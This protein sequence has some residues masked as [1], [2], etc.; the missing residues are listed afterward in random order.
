LAVKSVH[1]E[2]LKEELKRH[3]NTLREIERR[4]LELGASRRED[5]RQYLVKIKNFLRYLKNF[6]SSAKHEETSLQTPESSSGREQS[7]FETIAAKSKADMRK[8]ELESQIQ[9]SLKEEEEL[10]PRAEAHGTAHEELDD[11]YSGIFDGPTPGFP[12]EDAAESYFDQAYS[13][14]GNQKALILSRRRAILYAQLAQRSCL[15]GTPH[16]RDA[17]T[18][19]ETSSLT[20]GVRV[21]KSDLLNFDHYATVTAVELNKTALQL[22]PLNEAQ[23]RF[24]KDM[25]RLIGASALSYSKISQLEREDLVTAVGNAH[26]IWGK[27]TVQIKDFVAMVKDQERRAREGAR[28]TARELEE[29]R[30]A[31][32][33]IRQGVFETV[34]GF[35]EAPPA[36]HNCCPRHATYEQQCDV[37][38]ETE[39]ENN[40]HDPASARV[41]ARDLAEP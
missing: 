23:H 18:I 9:Q 41:S 10:K 19:A 11:L 20:R 8:S 26:D 29:K 3:N 1:I 35:G 37:E 33:Q 2:K 22:A 17:K 21:L 27:L 38:V 31:L 32:Q 30:S 25:Q 13:K 24:I 12:N 28:H 16:I 39:T 34:V 40:E 7:Y 5:D 4:L 6:A 36:Y 15:V 14:H